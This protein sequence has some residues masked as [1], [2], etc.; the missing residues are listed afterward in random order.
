MT[1]VYRDPIT[2]QLGGALDQFAEAAQRLAA[3][4]EMSHFLKRYAWDWYCHLTFAAP[5]HI[6]VAEKRFYDWI[7]MVNRKNFGHS[8]YKHRVSAYWARVAELQSHEV[9]HFHVLLG[10]VTI[11][12]ARGVQSWAKNGIAKIDLFDA[13]KEGVDYLL[14]HDEDVVFSQNLGDCSSPGFPVSTASSSY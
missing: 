11:D 6:K 5:V 8:Y 9:F 7:H 10:G 14:K 4:E 2:C 12:P 3:R 13:T 1:P